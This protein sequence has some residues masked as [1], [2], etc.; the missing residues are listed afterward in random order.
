MDSLRSASFRTG[1]GFGGARAALDEQLDAMEEVEPEPVNDSQEHSDDAW[2][3]A[4][5]E[6][7]NQDVGDVHEALAIHCP[8]CSVSAA[9]AG[10][11]GWARLTAVACS[12]GGAC[13]ILLVESVGSVRVTRR[14]AG[15]ACACSAYA[16]TL[17]CGHLTG[18]GKAW[19]DDA[20]LFAHQDA[21]GVEP[22]SPAWA[23]TALPRVYATAPSVQ[24]ERLQAAIGALDLGA[25]TSPYRAPGPP[26]R[27]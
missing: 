19:H 18:L 26:G 2:K 10:T 5:A 6:W 25:L 14:V 27:R 12:T 9:R 13:S 4:V 21:V 23:V 16:L 20:S 24:T 15:A 8:A 17:L 3:A 7:F 1:L 11:P 22:H